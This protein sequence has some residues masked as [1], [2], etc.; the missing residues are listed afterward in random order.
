MVSQG[1]IIL[2]SLVL[3]IRIQ[4]DPYLMRWMPTLG[5]KSYC[6]EIFPDSDSTNEVLTLKCWVFVAPR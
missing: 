3:S 2:C 5:W 6:V 4:A 1:S